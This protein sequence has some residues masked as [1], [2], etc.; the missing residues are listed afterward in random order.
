MSSSKRGRVRDDGYIRHIYIA[1]LHLHTVCDGDG[2]RKIPQIFSRS[3]MTWNTHLERH[4]QGR[5]S[6]ILLKINT[7]DPISELEGIGAEN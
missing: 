3:I 7:F 5:H 2:V 6:E 1:I 4:F